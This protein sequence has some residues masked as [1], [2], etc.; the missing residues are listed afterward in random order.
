MQICWVPNAYLAMDEK[1]LA[2]LCSG[3]AQPQWWGVSSSKAT[4]GSS[5]SWGSGESEGGSDLVGMELDQKRNLGQVYPSLI[6]NQQPNCI[7]SK[8][9]PALGLSESEL[10]PSWG[11]AGWAELSPYSGLSLLSVSQE[12]QQ[13]LMGYKYHPG[14]SYFLKEQPHPGDQQR[15]TGC[16]W[17]RDL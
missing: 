5:Y 11:T 10:E 2:I 16:H 3:L 4:L 6:L 17:I 7:G 13:R 9:S 8:P 14:F 15:Q 12:R 1:G